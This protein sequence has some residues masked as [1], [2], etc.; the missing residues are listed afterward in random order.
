MRQI[1]LQRLPVVAVFE[2]N[3]DRSFG[4]GVE[5]AFAHRVF[6]NHVDGR[7]VR[8]TVGDFRPRFAVI[9]RAVNM[10]TQIV[11]TETVDG[12]VRGGSIRVRSLDDGD[13]APRRELRRR[14]VV[15]GFSTVAREVN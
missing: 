7:V 13:F 12:G 10:R 11:E 3:V 14:D 5:Q 15:P 4:A 2:G 8:Q 1:Q 9:A 6:A